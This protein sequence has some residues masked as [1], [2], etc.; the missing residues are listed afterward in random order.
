MNGKSK[1]V[2]LVLCGQTTAAALSVVALWVALSL[3]GH[4]A[5]FLSEVGAV[6]LVSRLLYRLSRGPLPVFVTR[7]IRKRTWRVLI[8]E[9]V[10]TTILL[11]AAFVADWPV[12]KITMALFFGLNLIL[13]MIFLMVIRLALAVLAAERKRSGRS[14]ARKQAIILGTGKQARTV[15]DMILDSPEM[16]TRIIGFMDYRRHNLW[17]YRD[18]PLIGHPDELAAIVAT[19]Q[20]D[21][22]MIAVNSQDLPLTQPVFE[23]AEQMGVTICLMSEIFHSR[24]ARV[25]PGYINGIPTLIYRAVPECRYSLLAK[26]I[27]DRL[28]ALVGIVL[29][30][31]VMLATALWIKLDS[32][33]P[34][35]FSQV[36]S[37][38]NGKQFSILKFRTMGSDAESYKKDLRHLN[39]MSG[40]VFKIKEDPRVTRC[41]KFLRRFSIDE[42]PQFFNVLRGEMSLVGPRPPLPK[43]V[44][45]YDRWQH[46][47]LSVKPGL[48]CLW[49]VSG[50]SNV[51]F[52]DW[53][54][55]DLQYIDNW[56][57][58]LDAKIL[59]R[60]VPAVLK[61]DGAA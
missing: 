22:V 41:G 31:P 45:R 21:A 59:A 35:L 9:S 30:A 6:M 43:E 2:L 24:V 16:E 17:R 15:A 27:I 49:Q 38:L 61:S 29:T 8:D 4:S 18:I 42:L 23:V 32:R 56:S 33:G 37:G 48:T 51:D 5:W 39:E 55:L 47:K 20:V 60:T 28:G 10:I 54:K 25:R 14:Q 13:Q 40:P 1:Q 34:V 36:R 12:E 53:M 26:A 58:W 19:R 57:L 7:S 11:A 50:R 46:R 52:E 3:P 44:A